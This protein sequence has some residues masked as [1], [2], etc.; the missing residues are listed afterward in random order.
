MKSSPKW[1]AELKGKSFTEQF[2]TNKDG[3]PSYEDIKRVNFQNIPPKELKRVN[4]SL[5]RI[6]ELDEKNEIVRGLSKN[7]PSK[8]EPWAGIKKN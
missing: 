6:I 2:P 3:S 8:P 7:I 4:L 1:F 5:D